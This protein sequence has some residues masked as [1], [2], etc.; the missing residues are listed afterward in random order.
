MGVVA[1]KRNN[2][3]FMAMAATAAIA[4]VSCNKA[5][6]D[7]PEVPGNSVV[8]KAYVPDDMA[9]TTFAQEGDHYAVKWDSNDKVALLYNGTLYESKTITRSADNK[10][11]EFTFDGID[12][13]EGEYQLFYP[14][15]AAK[16]EDGV[17]TMN[18]PQSQGARL[19]APNASATI[20]M[21]DGSGSD[22]VTFRH[23]AAYAKMTV[24]GLPV[25]EKVDNVQ[26]Y[27]WGAAFNGDIVYDPS[28]GSVDYKTSVEKSS[29][30]VWFSFDTTVKE[31][32]IIDVWYALKP[33]TLGKSASFQVKTIIKDGAT[34]QVD[35]KTAKEVKFEAGKVTSFPVYSAVWKITFNTHGGSAVS[36][37]YIQKG[38]KVRPVKTS[39]YS[40]GLYEGDITDLEDGFAGWYKDADYQQPFDITTDVPEGDMTLH[41]KWDMAVPTPIKTAI[42]EA[43]TYISGQSGTNYTYLMFK[44]EDTWNDCKL[45]NNANAVLRIVGVNPE[46]KIT[47]KNQ[48]SIMNVN[49][50]KVIVENVDFTISTANQIKAP[51]IS[52]NGGS[53]TLGNGARI[54]NVVSTHRSA[55]VYVEAGESTFTLDGGEICN[56]TTNIPSDQ[57]YFAGTVSANWGKIVI[58]SGKIHDNAVVANSK[59]C[60]GGALCF[61]PRI[62]VEK[63]GGEIYDNVVTSTVSGAVLGQQV[64]RGTYSTLSNVWV[65]NSN[66]SAS[67]NF[68]VWDGHNPSGDPWIKIE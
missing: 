60:A 47:R 36:D 33:M 59:C 43:F 1:M 9:K 50:G 42:N 11:A 10:C 49:K 18:L 21:A 24:K 13:L 28:T 22:P 38:D 51:A 52:L 7:S 46:T 16:Y 3:K 8:V 29:I 26:L 67:T 39:I 41:A 6:I 17:V 40:H 27:K 63:T 56:C 44:N 58:K 61:P 31:D 15:S 48:Y 30:Y 19:T 34:Y 53:L 54:S 20:M 66:L 45:E 14:Y 57:G 2:F 5:E 68:N 4:L 25:G 35:L 12:S 23:L 55:A 62:T 32:G 65:I 64:M 37:Q